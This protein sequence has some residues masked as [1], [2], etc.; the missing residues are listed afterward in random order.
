MAEQI[1]H[2]IAMD[3]LPHVH[4][5]VIPLAAGLHVGLSGPFAL[6]RSTENTV[7]ESLP[8]PNAGAFFVDGEAPP[9]KFR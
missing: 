9:F 1:A 8:A 7:R 5:H 2:L 3:E 6:A 4:I